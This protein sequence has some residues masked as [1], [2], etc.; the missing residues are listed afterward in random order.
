MMND[1]LRLKNPNGE[2]ADVERQWGVQKSRATISRARIRV[3][4]VR[5]PERREVPTEVQLAVHSA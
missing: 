5:P 2:L 3:I 1:S 4:D